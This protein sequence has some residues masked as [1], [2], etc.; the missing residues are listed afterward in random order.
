MSIQ[1]SPIGASTGVT[2]DTTHKSRRCRIVRLTPGVHKPWEEG[3][4]WERDPVDQLK[5][6]EYAPEPEP[7]EKPEP[8]YVEPRPAPGNEPPPLPGEM[9]LKFRYE[10]ALRGRVGHGPGQLTPAEF[11]LLSMLLTYAD[12]DL[13]H[14]CPGNA[15]LAADCGMSGKGAAG[16]A[17][18]RAGVVASK[19]FSVVTRRG[20]N[21]GGNVS[22]E[23]RLKLPEWP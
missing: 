16:D 5:V 21:I 14:A 17:G 8:E 23:Y 13:C 10:K 1:G 7:T 19:G 20:T 18:K 2:Y 15:R 9:G 6:Y 12:E 3:V 11:V 22:Q 4:T